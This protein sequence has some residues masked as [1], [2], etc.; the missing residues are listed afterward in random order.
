ME[1]VFNSLLYVGR[2]RYILNLNKRFSLTPHRLVS[3][4]RL[5]DTQDTPMEHATQH[6]CYVSNKQTRRDAGRKYFFSLSLFSFSFSFFLSLRVVNMCTLPV[7]SCRGRGSR[8]Q[9]AFSVRCRT[10]RGEQSIGVLPSPTL[11]FYPSVGS[12]SCKS[13][14]TLR[15]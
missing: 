7:P 15:V 9:G 3:E 2:W 10:L 14:N 13:F 4:V 6:C 8:L 5:L 12:M 11:F 1:I